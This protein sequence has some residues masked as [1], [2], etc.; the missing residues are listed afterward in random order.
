[1][2]KGMFDLSGK[3]ALVTGASR[4]IGEA[5]AKGLAQAGAD[6]ALLARDKKAL[7]TVKSEIQKQTGKKVCAFS[8]DLEQLDKI[9]A[10]FDEIVK[11]TGGVDILVNCAGTSLRANAEDLPLADWQKVLD[12]NL[13]AVMK[14]S[15][16]FCRSRKKGEAGRQ[17]Y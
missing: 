2:E 15:Q 16:A 17:D 1:M 14:L 9:E 13:T 6:V 10:G 4:G 7:E 5:I 11:Q 8:L 3:C 12:I